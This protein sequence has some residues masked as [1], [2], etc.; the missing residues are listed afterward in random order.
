M[1]E[2][3]PDLP[4][5]QL[6]QWAKA[7]RREWREQAAEQL[8][9]R[10]EAVKE[11]SPKLAGKIESLP[12]KELQEQYLDVVAGMV[13]LVAALGNLYEAPPDPQTITRIVNNIEGPNVEAIIVPPSQEDSGSE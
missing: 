6:Q 1:A 4:R 3:N 9:R 12:T 10:I 2:L 7:I 13:V 5:W 8:S 11:I